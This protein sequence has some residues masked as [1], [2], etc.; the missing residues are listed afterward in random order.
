M[1]MKEYNDYQLKGNN[2]FGIPAL[3][4]RFIEYAGIEDL[5]ELYDRKIFEGKWMSVGCGANLLFCDDYHGAIIHSVAQGVKIQ[6]ENDHNLLVRA[7]A[8]LILDDFIAQTVDKGWGGME[9]LSAIPCSVGA[10]PVQNVG[11][12]GVEAKD[13]VES[14]LVFDTRD[15]STRTFTNAEC[16]FGYRNSFFKSNPQYVVVSV[17]FRLTKKS[18]WKL[19]LDYGN[20]RTALPDQFSENGEALREIREAVCRIRH[21]KLPDPAV[22]G[23]AGSFFKNPVVDRAVVDRLLCDY[24][25]MPFYEMKEGCKIPAGWM[26]EQ[27]GWKGKKMGNAGVYE[28]QAL[29][30]VNLGGAS[31]KEVWQLAQNIVDSVKE[32]FNVEISPEVIRISE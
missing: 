21:E 20:L 10:A 12:Y 30:L 8:G 27:S 9:N 25:K 29:V 19:R 14:V 13:V 4:D 2:T 26:I 15:G 1:H 16:D 11:A 23:S 24:P 18:D 31:G 28:K 7:E 6:E 22:I 17:D 5:K 3:C 32:K